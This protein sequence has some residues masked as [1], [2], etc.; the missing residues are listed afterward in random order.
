[1]ERRNYMPCRAKCEPVPTDCDAKLSKTLSMVLQGAGIRTGARLSEPG[2]FG[3]TVLRGSGKIHIPR[4]TPVAQDKPPDLL[5]ESGHYPSLAR[6]GR[7]AMSFALLPV[8][9]ESSS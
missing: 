2:V 4:L 5:S 6:G 1:L 3:K 8:C 9:Q 7:T